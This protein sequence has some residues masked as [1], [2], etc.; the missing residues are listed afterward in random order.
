MQYYQEIE[1]DSLITWRKKKE[2]RQERQNAMIKSLQQNASFFRKE[3]NVKEWC[4]ASVNRILL[5]IFHLSNIKQ[6]MHYINTQLWHQLEVY[7]SEHVKECSLAT[8]SKEIYS[9]RRG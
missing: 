7:K 4:F 2:R 5:K 9:I 1:F 6:I 3:K 8:D